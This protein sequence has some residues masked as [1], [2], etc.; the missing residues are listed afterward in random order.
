MS[1]LNY[2]MVSILFLCIYN[3]SGITGTRGSHLIIIV[4]LKIIPEGRGVVRTALMLP[5]NLP[6]D[7][8]RGV[9]I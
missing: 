3:P 9:P 2:I 6:L 4:L 1:E 5:F 8:N 7:D